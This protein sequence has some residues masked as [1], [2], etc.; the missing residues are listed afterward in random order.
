ML[1]EAEDPASVYIT[2]TKVEGPTLV[3]GPGTETVVVETTVVETVVVRATVITDV[4]VVETAVVGVV[5]WVV[6]VLSVVRVGGDDTAGLSLAF[7]CVM[8]LTGA[9]GTVSR[10]SVYITEVKVFTKEEVPK[11]YDAV[12]GK[13]ESE[14]H[15]SLPHISEK[16]SSL[17]LEL[18]KC[19]T[20][21]LALDNF[22]VK[23]AN[24]S[25]NSVVFFEDFSLFSGLI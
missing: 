7:A 25:S 19:F 10:S 9:D 3:D 20:V 12:L 17:E 4:V 16:L 24:S 8:S 1:V 18:D 21:Y 11:S 13:T 6:E 14:F 5:P 23:A 15:L 2:E 22:K